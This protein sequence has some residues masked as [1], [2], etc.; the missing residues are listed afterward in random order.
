MVDLTHTVSRSGQGAPR[1]RK[2]EG[3]N[4]RV[5]VARPAHPWVHAPELLG[6]RHSESPVATWQAV[7]EA[8]TAFAK[9]TRRNG[10]IQK[11]RK[12]FELS[13]QFLILV[14]CGDEDHQVVL[15]GRFQGEGLEVKALVGKVKQ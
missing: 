6:A 8:A 3:G 9:F 1:K 11:G 15:L 10:E 2:G 7:A 5:A 4:Q 12:D 14:T 13:E